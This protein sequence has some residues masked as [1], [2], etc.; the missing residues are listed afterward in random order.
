MLQ[1]IMPELMAMKNVLVLNDE[2]NHCYRE[3][4][5]ARTTRS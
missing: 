3:R 4:R 5:P 1:R 2:A